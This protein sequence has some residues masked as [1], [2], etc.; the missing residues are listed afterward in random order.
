ML[1]AVDW[2]VNA[3]YAGPEFSL[4]G[5]ALSRATSTATCGRSSSCSRSS[6][7]EARGNS[8]RRRARA[9][10][11]GGDQERQQPAA[12]GDSPGAPEAHCE[13]KLGEVRPILE[14]EIRAKYNIKDGAPLLARAKVAKEFASRLSKF[15][16]S[17]MWNALGERA[18]AAPG[19]V[20]EIAIPQG[21]FSEQGAG[22]FALGGPQLTWPARGRGRAMASVR[23]SP[24]AWDTGWDPT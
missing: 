21:E 10:A 12:D 2:H 23:S 13:Q 8:S 7:P 3:G 15:A 22:T 1:A 18:A 16:E 24:V 19:S 11:R 20:L 17:E 6:R 14:A 9:R 4:R 5:P